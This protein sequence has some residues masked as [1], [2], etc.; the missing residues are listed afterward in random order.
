MQQNFHEYSFNHRRTKTDLEFVH[1]ELSASYW[2]KDIPIEIVK[3]AMENSLFFNIFLKNEQVGF[4]RV[5]TDKCTYGYLCDVI[6]HENH[7]AKGLG[8]ALMNFIMQHPDL[9]NLR[10]FTLVTRDAHALYEKF[11]FSLTKHPERLMEI[12]RPGIY[13]K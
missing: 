11:G 2:A 4:A 1:H 8:K 10:R 5:V 7:R 6:I 13:E 12:H 3:R 9:Q